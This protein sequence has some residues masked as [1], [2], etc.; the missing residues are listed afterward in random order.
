MK[1]LLWMLVTMTAG[2]VG[3]AQGGGED[4]REWMQ[5]QFNDSKPQVQP[6]NPPTQ[7][8]PQPY[9]SG[10]ADPFGPDRLAAVL[11][12]SS[13]TP[14]ASSALLASEQRRRKEPLESFPL[15]DMTLVGLL[16]R[17]GR[18]VALLKVAGLLHQVRVGNYL[19]PNFGR[20]T[21][22][23]EAEVTLRE[24]VQDSV[25][26]WSERTATLQLQEEISR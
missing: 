20:V 3:C 19:G 11:Q 14:V 17:N 5:A 9:A 7:F 2:L 1:P 26:E 22:I 16:D 21:K 23:T 15:E 24:I 4:L 8:V 13:A 10:G 25:G 12:G 6:I 18:K